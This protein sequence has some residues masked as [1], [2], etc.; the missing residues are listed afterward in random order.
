[1]L[2]QARLFGDYVM[3]YARSEIELEQ[4]LCA[5]NYVCCCPA[6]SNTAIL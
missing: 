2:L 4:C 5:Y 1:M 3:G 6:L